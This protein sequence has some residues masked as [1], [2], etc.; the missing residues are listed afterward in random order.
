MHIGCIVVH[1]YF[2]MEVVLLHLYK[3]NLW[4]CDLYIYDVSIIMQIHANTW[5]TYL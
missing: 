4:L 2:T 1:V 5:F 3:I